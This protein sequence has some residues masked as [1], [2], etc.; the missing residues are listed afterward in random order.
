[1]Q[2]D[3]NPVVMCPFVRL[4]SKPMFVHVIMIRMNMHEPKQVWKQN[5]GRMENR[6]NHSNAFRQVRLDFLLGLVYQW[7]IFSPVPVK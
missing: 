7:G 4:C 2:S 1:M 3:C 6:C 5:I